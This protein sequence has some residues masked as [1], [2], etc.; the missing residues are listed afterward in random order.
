MGIII[1]AK[2]NY[3]PFGVS[4]RTT[5]FAASNRDKLPG[6]VR[7]DRKVLRN[8]HVTN[9]AGKLFRNN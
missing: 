6:V 7:L 4:V 8:P 2:K 9:N 5:K 3:V 1:G